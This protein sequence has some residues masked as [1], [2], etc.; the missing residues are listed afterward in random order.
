MGEGFVWIIIPMVISNLKNK[1]NGIISNVI[2]NQL[3]PNVRPET[4]RFL[5]ENIG[6]KLL[7]IFCLFVYFCGVFIF[8]LFLQKKQK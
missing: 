8:I 4:I 5:A 2:Q 3:D 6:G 1:T 7:V